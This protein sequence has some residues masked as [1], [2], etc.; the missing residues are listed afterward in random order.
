MNSSCIPLSGP[1]EIT[2]P[3]KNNVG[4]KRREENFI[5]RLW[6]YLTI[7]NL[8]EKKSSISEIKTVKLEEQNIN[9]DV[10]D[11]VTK[12]NEEE[13]LRLALSYNFVTQLTSLLVFQPTTNATRG[14]IV[15]NSTVV[16]PLPV[17][18]IS[19][20][21]FSNRVVTGGRGRKTSRGKPG[22]I[23]LLAMGNPSKIVPVSI[24]NRSGGRGKPGGLRVTSSGKPR[25]IRVLRKLKYMT[26]T[27]NTSKIGPVSTI[28]Q[29]TPLVRL[30]DPVY[31]NCQI[32][33][34]EKTYLRGASVVINGGSTTVFPELSTLSFNDKTSSLEVI[35]PCCWELFEDIFFVGQSKSFSKGKYK[36]ST[37]LGATLAKEV[38]SLRIAIC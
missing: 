4:E 17:N 2:N 20:T 22:G 3:S 24:K 11:K 33:L 32:E 26:P 6:A 5:E 14:D 36:S 23:R 19:R 37:M 15:S 34:F 12:S 1:P 38:S 29:S 9:K 25:R 13:A 35:G 27:E 8:L 30:Y 16:N 21:P 10:L 7:E 18:S 31:S 28:T